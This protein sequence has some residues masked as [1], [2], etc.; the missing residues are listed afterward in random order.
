MKE[1]HPIAELFPLMTGAEFESL[2]SDIAENGLRQAIW[3]H[4]DGRIVDGRNRY[5]ACTEL[6]I[7]PEYRT[8]N[9]EGSLVTFVVSLNLHRRHLN[10][11]QR[12]VVTVDILPEARERQLATLKQN[13]SVVEKIPQRSGQGKARTQA[14]EVVGTNE[15]YVSDAK[16]LQTDAPELLPEVRAGTLNILQAKQ[17]AT[18][19]VVDRQ[20]IVARG[21]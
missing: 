4:T 5:R 14:A 11:S 17:L 16:A 6:G 19:P 2:K 9:G 12:A 18:L 20:E 13:T 1:F 21:H 10:S 3:L 15:R 8:W 7:E